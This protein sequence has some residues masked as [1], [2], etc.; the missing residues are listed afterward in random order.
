MTSKHFRKLR[1]LSEVETCNCRVY[2]VLKKDIEFTRILFNEEENYDEAQMNIIHHKM[3]NILNDGK[4]LVINMVLLINLF[5]NIR[6]KHYIVARRLMMYL[7]NIKPDKKQEIL[8]YMHSNFYPFNIPLDFS[9]SLLIN[10]TKDLFNIDS[11]DQISPENDNFKYSLYEKSSIDD[12]IFNDNISDL[13]DYINGC[14][15]QD[16][17]DYMS[18]MNNC[19]YNGSVKCYKYIF[20]N[21][22]NPTEMTCKNSVAGG[23]TEIIQLLKQNGLSFDYECLI[24]SAIYHRYSITDW[25]I[26]HSGYNYRIHFDYNQAEKFNYTALV[27]T[28]YNKVSYYGSCYSHFIFSAAVS[29]NILLV[30]FLIGEC[31]VDKNKKHPYSRNES[32]LHL[33]CEYGHIPIVKYLVEEQNADI[34]IEDNYGYTPTDYAMRRNFSAIVNYLIS[35]G[36][37]RMIIIK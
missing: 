28:F 21:G 5:L 3:I 1:F 13:I 10:I 19:A 26:Y 22:C 8:E 29:G 25:I 37:K 7:I 6:R 14:P 18:M 33:A 16:S 32:S 31:R 20:L 23:N 9:F 17:I 35:H 36:G 15:N 4:H 30:K 11:A 2:N 34:N 12:I 24:E 27:F